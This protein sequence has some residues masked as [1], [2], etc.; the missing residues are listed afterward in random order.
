MKKLINK[1]KYIL[2]A[3]LFVFLISFL[4]ISSIQAATLSAA[5]LF[6]SRLKINL[7]GT[8]GQTVEMVLA[9]DTATAIPSGGTVTIEFPDAEDAMWCRTAGALTVT[10]QASSAADQSGTNWSIDTAMPN[11]GTALSATCSQGSGSSVDKITIIN[12]GALT[13]GTTYGVKLANNTGLLGTATTVGEHV[14]TVSANTGGIPVDCLC[15]EQEKCRL[16]FRKNRK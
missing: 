9:I 11:S 12:V 7:N 8:A 16:G 4:I 5:Y 1:L 6:L 14:I 10:S 3:T 13:A 15:R 2:P